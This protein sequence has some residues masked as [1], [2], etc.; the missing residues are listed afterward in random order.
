MTFVKGVYAVAIGVLIVLLVIFGVQ[1]FYPAPQYPA[2]FWDI[3][4]EIPEL[5]V[6]EVPDPDEGELV[7]PDNSDAKG[8]DVRQW[9]IPYAPG[10]H[11]YPEE[12]HEVIM[13]LVEEYRERR[14]M[15]YMNVFLGVL[16]LGALLAVGGTFVR[17]RREIAGASLVLGGTGT[18]IFAVVPW[19][20]DSLWRFVG[21]AVILAVLVLVG[22]MVFRSSIED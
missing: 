10:E 11:D 4:V 18:M 8:V 20:L 22:F 3:R 17:R 6:G 12:R 13:R 2:V 14:A 21:I 9:V 1:A 5:I 16:P 15:Y 19:R 7:P